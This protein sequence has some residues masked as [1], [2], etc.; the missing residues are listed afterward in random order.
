MFENTSFYFGISLIILGFYLFIRTAWVNLWRTRWIL[1]VD[2]YIEELK[3]GNKYEKLR[4]HT[5]DELLDVMESRGKMFCS[6]Y[7]WNIE[8]F[9]KKKDLFEEMKKEIEKN[10]GEE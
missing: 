8:R 4:E 3:K 6:I 2:F 7:T 5:V 9:I 10:K 1:I